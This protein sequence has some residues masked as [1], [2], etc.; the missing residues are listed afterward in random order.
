MI[1]HFFLD[2]TNTIIENSRENMGLNPILTI[3]YGSH[4]MRGLIHFDNTDIKKLIEDKTFCNTDKLKVYLKMTNCFS[5]DGNLNSEKYDSKKRAASFDLMLFKLPCEFDKGRGY[6]YGNDFWINNDKSISHYGSNWF[7]SKTQIPWIN[8]LETYIPEDNKGGI[9]GNDILKEEY[10]KFKNGEESL[11]IGEQHFDF[12]NENLCIDI[13]QYVIDTLKTDENYGLC[14]SF[15][16]IYEEIKT[17]VYNYVSFF[18]DNTN[19]FFHP[20]IEVVYDDY[21]FDCRNNF[22]ALNNKLYLYTFNN[23]VPCNL[24]KIPVCKIENIEFPVTQVNKGVYMAVISNDIINLK[25]DNVYYDEWSEIIL[26]GQNMD[27]IE[28]EFYVNK[29]DSLTN[30]GKRS[31]VK[32]NIIPS[33]YGINDNEELCR[34]EIRMIMVDFVEK[35][36]NNVIQITNAKYRIYVKDGNRELDV[37]N[38]H[39][40]EKTNDGSFF[41]IYTMDLIPNDYFVDIQITSDRE[42]KTHKNVLKFKIVDNISERYM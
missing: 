31:T 36:T 3:S 38:Y 12:G 15:T 33:I 14:L 6:D 9:Y 20:F 39:P 26:D 27:N 1:R 34:N 10:N 42:V 16:P 13:T 28:M 5:V 40:I 37:I 25:E 8:Y 41:N 32:S 24:D 23:N 18:T 4:L 35:Y 7:F 17:D 29:K 22:N 2:K 11:V 30:I 21:I 19:T